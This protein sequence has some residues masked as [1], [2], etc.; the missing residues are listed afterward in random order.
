[1]FR[2]SALDIKK[3]FNHDENVIQPTS[4]PGLHGKKRSEYK[5]SVGV[6]ITVT[7]LGSSNRLDIKRSAT[8]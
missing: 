8:E 2:N 3:G 4:F 1:M 5:F 7:I 6:F